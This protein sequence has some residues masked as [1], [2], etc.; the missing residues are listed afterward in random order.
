MYLHKTMYYQKK[1]NIINKIKQ[2]KINFI[3]KIK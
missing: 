1:I 2:K 3:N